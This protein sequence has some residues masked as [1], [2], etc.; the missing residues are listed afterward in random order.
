MTE[1]RYEVPHIVRFRV[2]EISQ[3]DTFREQK[4]DGGLPGAERGKW[5][6]LIG[7]EFSFGLIKI[8]WNY[9]DQCLYNIMNG[10]DTTLL[11]P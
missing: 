7:M 11:F 2:Y 5:D 6:F 4:V 9:T 1:A 8:F 3:A 10:M